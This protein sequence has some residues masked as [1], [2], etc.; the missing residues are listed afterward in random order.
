MLALA[1]NLNQTTIP[2][3]LLV[4]KMNPKI[5]SI[6]EVLTVVNHRYQV[7]YDEALDRPLTP[8]P[9]PIAEPVVMM[10]TPVL[11]DGLSTIHL[12]SKT[13]LNDFISNVRS[14]P[15][16]FAS[17]ECINA[18]RADLGN[19]GILQ[20]AELLNGQDYLMNLRKV[21]LRSNDIGSTGF[22]SFIN[23]L[24]N[25][26]SKVS[27][28]NRWLGKAKKSG[29][30]SPLE[31][32]DMGDNRIKSQG[33]N[34][35]FNLIV[36]GQFPHLLSIDVSANDLDDNSMDGFIKL[37]RD[38]QQNKINLPEEFVFAN[39]NI[40]ASKYDTVSAFIRKQI[41]NNTSS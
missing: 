16:L 23:G 24:A 12:H 33:V 31:C 9:E 27:K 19:E 32:L 18:N 37:L 26:N 20:L 40:S 21:S 35:L 4:I 6:Q 34:F 36:Q 2:L 28:F 8:S 15:D 30:P 11:E 25:R 3:E 17:L 14:S 10:K 13:E 1:K 29:T 5:Q 39:N 7:L 22:V 38:C 41:E